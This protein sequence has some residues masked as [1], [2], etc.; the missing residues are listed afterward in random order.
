MNRSNIERQAVKTNENIGGSI[1]E[2]A[3]LEA[4]LEAESDKFTYLQMLKGFI[5]DLCDMLQ[6]KVYSS[7]Q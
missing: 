1:D 3:R 7:S 2:C 5:A 6:V 4:R